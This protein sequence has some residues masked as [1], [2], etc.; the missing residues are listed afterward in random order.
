MKVGK[1]DEL[2]VKEIDGVD[3]IGI[4]DLVTVLIMKEP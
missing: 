1:T 3:T 4:G 2:L